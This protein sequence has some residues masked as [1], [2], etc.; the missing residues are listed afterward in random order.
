MPR[1]HEPTQTPATVKP[2]GRRVRGD[3]AKQSVLDALGAILLEG[4]LRPSAQRIAQRAGVSLRLLYHHFADLETIFSEMA[5]RQ[6]ARVQPLL[7]PV[8]P[9]QPL[10]ARLEAL[11]DRRAELYETIT[12]VRRAGLLSEPSSTILSGSLNLFRAQKRAQVETLFVRELASCADGQRRELGA[13]LGAAASFAAWDLLRAH[14][15]LSVEEAK[16]VTAVTLGA[17]LQQTPAGAALD[18]AGVCASIAL[19]AG[20][21]TPLG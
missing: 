20:R 19:R 7:E 5:W 6:L 8:P 1:P 14:L 18:P 3:R 17:L 9:A 16:Q 15:R 21:P 10:A 11:I 12:P 2:D 4:E 13:A